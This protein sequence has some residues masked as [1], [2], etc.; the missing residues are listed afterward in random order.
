VC[1]CVCVVELHVTV[2]NT[3]ILSIAQQWLCGN[4]MLPATINVPKSTCKVPAAVLKQNNI[5]LIFAF[6]SGNDR[7]PVFLVLSYSI[8][9]D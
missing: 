1:V 4:F 5:R 9:Q 6:C 7:F 3:E 8:L 2:N